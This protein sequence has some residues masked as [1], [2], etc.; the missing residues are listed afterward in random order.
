MPEKFIKKLLTDYGLSNASFTKNLTQE[1]EAYYLNVDHNLP[2]NMELKREYILNYEEYLSV[3]QNCNSTIHKT[4]YPR[5]GEYTYL[6]L[7][8]THHSINPFIIGTFSLGLS[9][10]ILGIR[11]LLYITYQGPRL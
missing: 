1:E 3:L 10:N 7:N 5:D 9:E 4:P 6:L 11:I 2:K 8:L